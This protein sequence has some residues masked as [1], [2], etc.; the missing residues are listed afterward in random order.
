VGRAFFLGQGVFVGRLEVAFKTLGSDGD[1][2]GL[3]DCEWFLLAHLLSG[4]GIF[5]TDYAHRVFH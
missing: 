4:K 3:G 2:E 1:F 5:D